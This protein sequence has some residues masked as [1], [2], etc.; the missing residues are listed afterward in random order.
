MSDKLILESYV[1]NRR[2]PTNYKEG[3]LDFCSKE[4]S[5]KTYDIK[6]VERK[7]CFVNH[8]GFVYDNYFH[9]NEESLLSADHYSGYFN[10]KH[11]LKKVVLK[12]KRTVDPER[13][14]LLTFN[15]WGHAHYHWFCDT[16]PRIYS[17]KEFLKDYYLLLPGNS[18]YIKE[19]G[20]QTLELLGLY[21]KGIEFI[22]YKE[23]IRAKQLSIVT[24]ACMPGY[25]NDLILRQIAGSI[26]ERLGQQMGRPFR[27]LYISREG[28]TFRKV[29]NEGQV[30]EVVKHFGYEV[31]RFEDM[32]LREQMELMASAR[33]VV[34]IHGAGL[35]NIL[36]MQAGSNVL[37]FRRDR[38]YH[39]QCYWHLADALKLNYFY[40]F[41]TPDDDSLV[42]ESEGCNLTIDIP[43][44]IDT[45][46]QMDE[47]K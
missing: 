22:E 46:K 39:N 45:L 17:A 28:A 27:K 21:P 36:F 37:E 19:I 43:K 31:I 38:I 18:P 15:E 32:T 34:S 44:L 12:K 23:I 1:I 29:L 8:M 4:F 30:Q 11:Y 13:K 41:G 33:A 10:F 14:Y 7:D 47:K 2:F 26:F 16:L 20:L 24:H 42:I 35:T 9:I 25:S 5:Y 6:L 3:E 40:L